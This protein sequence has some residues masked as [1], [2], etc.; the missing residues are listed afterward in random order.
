MSGDGRE[1]PPG[2]GVAEATTRRRRFSFVWL[3]P[4]AALLVAGY[5]GWRSLS[6]RGPLVTVTFRNADGLTAGQTAVR[7]KAVQVGTVEAVRLSDDLRQ[8]RAAIR[9]NAEIAPRLTERARFW[10]VRPRL[11]AG[12]VSGLETIV[13]GSFIEFDP[14]SEQGEARRDFTGLDDPP[15]VRS[16][17][18]GRVFTLEA[19]RAGSL[20]RGSPVIFHDVNVGEVLGLDA[21]GL[22]GKVNLRAFVRAPYDRYLREG[23]RFWNASGVNL[24]V[25]AEGVKLELESLRALLSGGVAFDTPSEFQDQPP[26][27]DGA[28]FQLYEDLEAA[29]A[30]TS[31]ERLEFLVYFDGSVR[32]LGPGAPVEMRGVRIGSVLDRSLEFVPADETFRVPVHLAIEPSRISFPEAGAV[33]TKE[34][35]LSFTRRMVERG[36]RAQ[37]QSASLLTGQMLVSLDFHPDAAPAEARLQ[38]GDIVLPS[39]GGGSD[40]MGALSGVAGRIERLPLDEIGRN[41]NAALASVNGLVGGP[42]L[43]GAVGALSGALEGVQELVRTADAGLTPLM[44]RLPGIASNLDQAIGRA[45]AAVAS[46]QRGYG[47]DSTV[48]REL[49]RLLARANDTA[50][51]VRLLAEYLDRHPEA[52]IRGRTDRATER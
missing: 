37:L 17:E 20:D 28:R 29:I 46:I 15:G 5:L 21:P 9:M 41:L 11:T 2:P 43:R 22:D 4:L 39:L 31:K 27:P 36:L 51:S 38:G 45:N 6:D 10:V 42:E 18:P 26:V 34:D 49:E 33:R 7:Y 19:R 16:D 30:A 3:V 47:G 44:R 13:S 40:L 14:G 52:L 32:G 24:R 1:A 50:R 48:N 23:S 8:V 12:N 25:G 35:V